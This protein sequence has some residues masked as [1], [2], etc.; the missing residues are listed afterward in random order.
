MNSSCKIT[1]HH[2]SRYYILMQELSGRSDLTILKKI[3]SPIES[4]QAVEDSSQ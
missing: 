1:F 2:E 4:G 3:A